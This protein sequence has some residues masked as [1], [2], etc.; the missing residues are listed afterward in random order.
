MNETKSSSCGER[1]A[2]VARRRDLQAEGALAEK[3]KACKRQEREMKK[4]KALWD[5]RER[6]LTATQEKN[7][8]KEVVKRYCIRNKDRLSNAALP[9][10]S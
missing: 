7:D 6:S 1:E 2:E 9:A 3:E 10:R 5:K 4:E 8:K